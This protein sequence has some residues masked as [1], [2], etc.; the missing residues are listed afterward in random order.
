MFDIITIGTAT[1]DIF[2]KS[3]LFKIVKGDI[4]LKKFGIING[5]ATCFGLGAK[6]DVDEAFFEFGGGATNTAITFSRQEFKA[7]AFIKTGEDEYKNLIS[8]RLKKEKVSVFCSADKNKKTALSVILIAPDGERTILVYRG[9]SESLKADDVINKNPKAKWAYIAPG[10]M[11]FNETKKLIDYLHK[12]KISI[13]INP[14]KLLIQK[15]LKKLEP[16]LKKVRVL[17]LNREEAAYLTG[18]KYDNK[19]SIFKKLDAAVGGITLMT[20][21][22]S[23]SWVSDNN[24]L[25]EAD[26]FKG[27]KIVDET[28][29]GD[30]FGSGFVAGLIHRNELCKKGLCHTKNI[31]YAI[32]LGSANAASV[33]EYIGSQKGILTK[34]EFEQ[35]KR[36]VDLKIRTYRL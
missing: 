7:G 23:G 27:L 18:I 29:A 12:K 26:T 17:I 14:S 15:G 1:R 5:E 35:G 3:P 34:K 28:G 36:W 33:V 13:A 32:R 4:K 31:E 8:N 25:Y 16:V 24:I 19:K 9:A 11:D 22:R 6:I 21:G 20:D 10:K 30:A 2:L